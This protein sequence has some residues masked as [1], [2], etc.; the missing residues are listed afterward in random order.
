MY[1]DGQYGVYGGVFVPEILT[2]ALLQLKEEF[3]NCKS[4]PVFQNELN[5]LLKTFAGRPTPLFF[6]KNLS[7]ETGINIYLKREDLLHG[8]A[9]KTNQ[10]VAQAL[11]AKRMGKTNVIAETGAGQH[12]VATAMACA[13]LNLKCTVYMGSKDCS[14]QEMNVLRMK[15]LG[16]KV[17]PVTNGE[18]TLKEACSE[19]LRDWSKSYVDTHYILGTVAGPDPFPE[20]VKTFQSVIGKEVKEQF[21][22]STGKLP[23]FVV[24]CVG[25]GSNALGIFDEFLEDE[26]VS[27]IG[28]EPYGKGESTD[29][30]GAVL[31][32]GRAGILHGS[33]TLVL[34]DYEGQIKDSYS[35]SAGLDYPGVGPEH[36][37]LRDTKRV[38]YDGVL[39][40]EALDSFQKLCK[41]EGII[42]AL[43]SAH[44]LAYVL[45]NPNKIFSNK[46]VI[47]NLSGRGDKDLHL[48]NEYIK[49]K[50]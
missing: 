7:N 40:D 4:D 24:A 25:G 31:K 13:L 11:L 19:A 5:I 3:L 21:L 47:V 39:D 2:P 18:G 16:A 28:V 33:K 17:V 29:Q 10:V 38:Q 6:C 22:E 35:I 43:E 8:G 44:A 12:G 42:P 14:R 15:L 48:V 50:I 9:H 36:A 27:L 49:D 41:S 37:F 34:Q 45:K 32:H 1:S 23:D 30:H 46:N 26:K 20:M